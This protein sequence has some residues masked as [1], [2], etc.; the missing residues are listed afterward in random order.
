MANLPTTS[1][2]RKR[3]TELL[4]V[5]VSP[6]EMYRAGQEDGCQPELV[7]LTDILFFLRDKRLGRMSV[8]QESNSHAIFKIYD[9]V[10]CELGTE[11]N[12]HYM[13]GFLAGALRVTGR[14]DTV[15]V[16]EVSCGGGPGCDCVFE[17]HW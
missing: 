9:C 14:P 15:K 12:C 3:I 11:H 6:R 8:I 4:R 10:C 7:N 1:L 17:A 2:Y 5:G 13:A 16:R